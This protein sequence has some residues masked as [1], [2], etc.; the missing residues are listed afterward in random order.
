M[1]KC[2]NQQEYDVMM[3]LIVEM[4]SIDGENKTLEYFCD[5]MCDDYMKLM[6]VVGAITQPIR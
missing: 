1:R 3:F 4:V 6:E 2:S 5:M